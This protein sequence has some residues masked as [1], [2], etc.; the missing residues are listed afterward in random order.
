M[1]QPAADSSDSEWDI[2]RDADAGHISIP[3][4]SASKGELLEVRLARNSDDFLTFYNVHYRP[5]KHCKFICR[6]FKK[7]IERSKRKTK[8][9]MLRS[10]SENGAQMLMMNLVFTRTSFLY[11]LAN[12]E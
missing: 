8:L 6:S 4:P 10:P 12:T 9:C 5:S 1:S 3:G 2:D 11:T 7:R